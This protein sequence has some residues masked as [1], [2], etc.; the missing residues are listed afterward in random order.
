LGRPAPI[1][2]VRLSLAIWKPLH[3][4]WALLCGLGTTSAMVLGTARLGP[5]RVA[6][7]WFGRP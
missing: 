4:A 2:S 1:V 3:L 5:G 7:G 6:L